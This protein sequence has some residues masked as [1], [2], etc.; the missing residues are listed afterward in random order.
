MHSG[1]LSDS[2]CDAREL[3]RAEMVL[4]MRL[5]H[6]LTLRHEKGEATPE[7]LGHAPFGAGAWTYQETG[8]V[9]A[10]ASGQWPRSGIS[11]SF[12]IHNG[13]SHGQGSF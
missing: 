8:L 6:H 10:L 13:S 11:R 12:A 1:I 2:C 5:M 3:K 4:R 9:Q 7:P